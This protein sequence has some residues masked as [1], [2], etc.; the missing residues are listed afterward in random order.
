MTKSEII[1]KWI[2]LGWTD[3]EAYH[4]AITTSQPTIKEFHPDVINPKTFWTAADEHFETDPVANSNITKSV[5][6]IT[7]SNLNNHKIA[8]Y[9][10]LFNQLEFC[11]DYYKNLKK[12]IK[13]AEIGCGYGSLYYNYITR[14]GLDYI[15]FDIIK[16]YEEV[17]SIEGNDGTFSYAQ[18]CKY[19]NEFNVFYTSNTFQHLSPKQIEKYLY[20]V[21][22]MLPSGGFFNL[23]Y[24]FDV[25]YTYH[26]G[27]QIEIIEEANFIDLIRS[28]GYSIVYQSKQF[29][30]D[31]KPMTF[32]LRK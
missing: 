3:A 10:G 26:Y 22:D 28:V 1:S 21:Y 19:K 9:S 18:E 25:D 8:R 24:I 15:G 20:Q 13:I 12:D 6:S 11:V 14:N 30:G 31:I 16:R 4:K 23:M 27:Q 5:M 29:I 2:E 17:V 7:Q 32:L